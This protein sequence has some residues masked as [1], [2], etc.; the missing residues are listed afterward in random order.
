VS[1]PIR[2][3]HV[4]HPKAGK[5]EGELAISGWVLAESGP[6]ERVVAVADGR[7]VARVR[8]DRPRPDIAQ[9]VPD[10]PHA[11]T[12]GFR[13]FLPATVLGGASEVVIGA[14]ADGEPAQPIW[15]LRLGYT[16]KPG[17]DAARGLPKATQERLDAVERQLDLLRSPVVRDKG[18]DSVL[19]SIGLISDFVSADV[20]SDL[21]A[22]AA[23]DRLPLPDV[24]NR[25]GYYPD[26]HFRYWHSGLND[27]DKVSC[28]AR[29]SSITGGRFY[30]FGGSTGRVFR[31]FCCQDPS[32]EVWSSDFKLASVLWNQQNM[33]R[34][35]RCFLN[36]FLPSLPLPDHYFDA[37]TAFSVFT[38][39][40]DLE[41]PWLLELRRV[42]KPGGFLYLTVHD[43]EF[44]E[45]MPSHLLKV[46]Q[47]SSNG[48]AL[49]ESSS[50]PG[51]RSAFHWTTASY[52]SC[53]VFHSHTYIRAQWGRF[54]PEIEI[55]PSDAEKQCVVV[56]RY[57]D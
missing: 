41:L 44:W 11:Q 23:R 30:D 47:Q 4:D 10:L 3:G 27:F 15:R 37:V 51:P 48:A 5:L 18:Q 2:S 9:A 19:P 12:S 31:H 20:P 35:I 43:E 52:Y 13:M 53:N 16:P 14:S 8:A 6:V 56:L 57:W 54:F 45:R 42:L 38:H 29:E 36:G 25:E 32:F 46:L 40:D 21:A 22:R 24:A 26:N 50:F 28:F 39:I 33:P 55:R 7:I 1:A 49:T 17:V 34:Q